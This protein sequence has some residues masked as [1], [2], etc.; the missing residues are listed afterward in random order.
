MRDVWLNNNV[1]IA[2][3]HFSLIKKICAHHVLIDVKNVLHQQNAINVFPLSFILKKNVDAQMA[4][5]LMAMYVLLALKHVRSVN[6]KINVQIVS[7]H[8]PS[9]MENVVEDL[10]LEFF[11]SLLELLEELCLQ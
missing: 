10:R 3:L 8:T 2:S 9:L 1:A 5:L 7:I 4:P 6:Q 11:S